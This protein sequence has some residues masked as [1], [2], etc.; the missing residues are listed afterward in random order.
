VQQQ[1]LLP[2]DGFGPAQSQYPD[3]SRLEGVVLQRGQTALPLPFVVQSS[4]WVYAPSQQRVF[5]QYR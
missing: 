1:G 4:L 3:V 5:H 2:A